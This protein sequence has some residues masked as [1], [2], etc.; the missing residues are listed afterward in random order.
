MSALPAGP[1]RAGLR[2]DLRMDRPDIWRAD[3]L[4]RAPVPARPSGF[5][6]LDAELPGGGWPLGMVT[7]LIARDPGIG[8]L[9]LLIPLLRQLTL[10]RRIVLLLAPPL[11]PYAPALAAFGVDL[12]YLIVIRA[13]HAADRLWAVEQTLKSSSFGALLAWLPQQRT[14][15]EHLRRM[16]LAAQSCRG[17]VFLLRELPA[18][19]ESSPAPLRLLL[20]P[21][22]A[23]RLS[24]QILKRR[25]PLLADPLELTLPQPPLSLQ[26]RQRP[27]TGAM[28]VESDVGNRG[29]GRSG[30]RPLDR[31][32]GGARLDDTVETVLADATPDAVAHDPADSDETADSVQATARVSR[33][34]QQTD[35]TRRGIDTMRRVHT[36]ITLPH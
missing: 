35:R 13:S 25:G 28:P 36:P 24:V 26:L 6:A 15:P 22:P 18:Q 8:E 1:I 29:P 30:G 33:D 3:Q 7:E 11:T 19:F 2:S 9:R 31:D 21:R 5:T 12:D 32:H 16:Q 34:R 17:P 4:V 27:A 23:Q 20:L 10:E 14:R